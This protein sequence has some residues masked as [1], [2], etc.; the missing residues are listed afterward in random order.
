LAGLFRN[1]GQMAGPHFRKARW[2]FRSLTGSPEEMIEAEFEVGRDM[3]HALAAEGRIDDDPVSARLL[4]NM[5]GRLAGRLRNRQRRFTF[6]ILIDPQINAFAMPGGF[7]FVTRSLLALCGAQENELAFVLGHEMAHVVRGH[8]MDRMV[9]GTVL[10]VAS[11]AS[12]AARMMNK[13][14]LDA[15]MAM[16]QRAYSRDQELE[17]D[18]FA[19][20]LM[21][22]AELD[23]LAG[24]AVLIELAQHADE[25]DVL[26]GYFST[27]PPLAERMERI[28]RLLNK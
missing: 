23:P 8:A 9:S 20:R 25:P 21:I 22:S 6:Q 17:A 10:N 1:L 18:A 4:A 2:V 15:A 24:A 13:T 5:G 19:V 7:I 12:I 3:A 26:S 11:R 16:L 27:H 28:R 14:M